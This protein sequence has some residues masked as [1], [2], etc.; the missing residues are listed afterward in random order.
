MKLLPLTEYN[1]QQLIQQGY[2]HACLLRSIAAT[3]RDY[4]NTRDY[5]LYEAV[6]NTGEKP[7]NICLPLMDDE[8][9]ALITN[10][11]IDCY[12]MLKK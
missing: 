9:S 5:H 7:A 11:N 3:E 4:N 2:T 10:D 6:K 1:R 8:V 12:I